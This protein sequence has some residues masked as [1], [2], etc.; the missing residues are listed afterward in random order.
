MT[1]SPIV[2]DPFGARDQFETGQGMAGLYRISKL[3]DAGLCSISQ[4]P[5]SIRVLLESVLRNCDG[6]VVTADNVRQLA[7]WQAEKP[8]AA[9][10]PFKPS[11]VVLQDFTGVPA[12][13]DLAAMRS[14][15]QRLGGNPRKVQSVDS[16]RSGD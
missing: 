15:M 9:E 5:Y 7:T 14:A 13:V 6:Y 8:A 12:V 4:L 1:A 2:S 11:R 3:D 16:G 10:I